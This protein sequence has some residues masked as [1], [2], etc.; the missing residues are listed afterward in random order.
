MQYV[1][2]WI[3]SYFNR[4]YF[5]QAIDKA[6]IATDHL[7][8]VGVGTGSVCMCPTGWMTSSGRMLT[9]TTTGINTTRMLLL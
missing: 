5:L 9:T 8:L 1:D 7:H 2:A 3:K 6:I 4:C